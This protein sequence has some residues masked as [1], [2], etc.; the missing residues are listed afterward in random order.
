MTK[1]QR[2]SEL[3]RLEA[4]IVG[5]KADIYDRVIAI[6][7]LRMVPATRAARPLPEAASEEEGFSAD[8]YAREE[9]QEAAGDAASTSVAHRPAN[10][11]AEAMQLVSRLSQLGYKVSAT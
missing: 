4:E 5:L 6:E 7:H 1:E 8:P 10:P 9:E 2:A 3:A 11:R